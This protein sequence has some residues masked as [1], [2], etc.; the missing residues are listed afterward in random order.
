MSQRSQLR[1]L[2]INTS[3]VQH[4]INTGDA[5]PIRVSVCG[6]I[7]TLL[8]A[9]RVTSSQFGLGDIIAAAGATGLGWV[10]FSVLCFLIIICKKL[11]DDS[12][13]LSVKEAIKRV[14]F[15]NSK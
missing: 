15:S 9:A 7:L 12:H 8:V 10:L 13:K 11:I 1:K 3:L 2:C 4:N 5:H 6:P 14:K